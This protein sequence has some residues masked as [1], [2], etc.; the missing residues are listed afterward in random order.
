MT[1]TVIDAER[2][3]LIQMQEFLEG[4]REIGF[5]VNSAEERR[6]FIGRLLQ[7]T[8]YPSLGKRE[9]GLVRQYLLRLSGLGRAQLTRLI[10]Q[11]S[12]TG[13]IEGGEQRRPRFVR[14]YTN[15]DIVLLT[16]VDEAHE[17]L[18]GPAVRRILQREHQVYGRQEF[19]RLSG[20]SASQLCNLRQSRL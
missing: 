9:K 2:V 20:I 3:S 19:E 12:K 1:V 18:S 11:W 8:K 10:Q 17:Q 5:E 14:R 13:R 6:Q 16:K 7:G 4:S 15:A